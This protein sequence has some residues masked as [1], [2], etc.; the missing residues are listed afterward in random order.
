MWLGRREGFPVRSLHEEEQR[1]GQLTDRDRYVLVQGNYPMYPT[2]AHNN[3]VN[4]A[5]RIEPSWP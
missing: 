5:T 1:E 3:G 2:H 4:S